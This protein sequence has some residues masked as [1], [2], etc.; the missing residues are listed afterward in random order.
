MPRGPPLPVS[1]AFK[2]GAAV[3]SYRKSM[4][5]VPVPATQELWQEFVEKN[6]YKETI[7]AVPRHPPRKWKNLTG[8]F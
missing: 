2:K 4:G 1:R 8:N 5:Q 3:D 7:E 6:K